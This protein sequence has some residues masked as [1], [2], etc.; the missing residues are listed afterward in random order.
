MKCACV[1]DIGKHK[2]NIFTIAFINDPEIF[3]ISCIC[4][5]ISVSENDDGNSRKQGLGDNSNTVGPERW[6]SG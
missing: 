5:S 1:R 2:E 3:S 4:G 6:V